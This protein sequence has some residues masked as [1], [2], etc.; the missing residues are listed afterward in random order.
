MSDVDPESGLF[1]KGEHKEV[2][3][4]NVQTACDKNA[5]VLEYSVRPGNHHD[6]K[7][8]PALYEKLRNL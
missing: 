6:S 7:T 2:F 1:H 5:Y 3:A 8:F 4:Y